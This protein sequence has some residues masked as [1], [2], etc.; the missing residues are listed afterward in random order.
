MGNINQIKGILFLQLVE[1]EEYMFLYYSRVPIKMDSLYIDEIPQDSIASSKQGEIVERGMVVWQSNQVVLCYNKNKE[2]EQLQRPLKDIFEFEKRRRLGFFFAGYPSRGRWEFNIRNYV[3][4]KPN[5]YRW[6][7]AL[8]PVIHVYATDNVSL[9]LERGGGGRT[10]DVLNSWNSDH[11]NPENL[12]QFFIFWGAGRHQHLLYFTP[13]NGQ[14]G[15]EKKKSKNLEAG[16]R[17]LSKRIK[18]I[19]SE[20]KMK[21]R[22]TKKHIDP[23]SSH[24]SDPV[25]SDFGRRRQSWPELSSRPNGPL[26]FSLSF[27]SWIKYKSSRIFQPCLMLSRIIY[28]DTTGSRRKGRWLSSLTLRIPRPRW[29]TETR[30]LWPFIHQRPFLPLWLKGQRRESA[31]VVVDELSFIVWKPFFYSLTTEN[32]LPLKSATSL[33][34]MSPKTD[35]LIRSSRKYIFEDNTYSIK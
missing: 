3:L 8:L 13:M 32:E 29:P 4:D 16:Q 10:R 15:K 17:Q 27:F 9:R 6:T 21:K 24:Q 35:L 23:L 14:N 30:D 26:F 18:A 5:L 12:Y 1:P 7:P 33:W 2:D 34:I 31:R 28:R 22:K 20:Q 19:R 25:E 11:P